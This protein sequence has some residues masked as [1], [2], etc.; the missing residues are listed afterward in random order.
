MV[1]FFG[2]K[3]NGNYRKD[4]DLPVYVIV[5]VI[6]LTLGP[7]HPKGEMLKRWQISKQP[8]LSRYLLSIL[9]FEN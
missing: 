9:F 3:K 4:F 7:L 1:R 2:T 6:V 5:V 8:A